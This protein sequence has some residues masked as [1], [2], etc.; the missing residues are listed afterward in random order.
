MHEKV[1]IDREAAT[2]S[3]FWS[4]RT[5]AE[6]NGMIFK[7]AKG[8]GPTNWH[9]HDDQDELFIVHEGQVTIQLHDQD[10]LLEKGDLFV[11]PR[12]VEHCPKAEEEVVLLVG[13]TTVTSAAAD[14]K[15]AWSHTHRQ[16]QGID[17]VA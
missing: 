12:G 9:K 15:P 2:I 16:P 5:V 3:E 1:N 11:V 7:L 17:G 14:G 10:V 8:I 6:A 4:Q 13:G